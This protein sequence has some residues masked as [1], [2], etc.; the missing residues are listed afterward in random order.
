MNN[1]LI[2][3]SALMCEIDWLNRS[4]PEDC[5]N[6]VAEKLVKLI[7]QAPAVDAMPKWI[8]VKD[9]LPEP[10]TE[11]LVWLKHIPNIAIYGHDKYGNLGFYFIDEYGYRC[12]FRPTVTYWMPLPEQ[13]KED[14]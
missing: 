7:E 3:R 8:S 4:Y 14:T 9:R 2:S 1:D 12:T 11:V 6:E 5:G 10:E 13:P